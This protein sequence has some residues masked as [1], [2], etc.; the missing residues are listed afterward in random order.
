MVSVANGLTESA[1]Y[2]M[3][4]LEIADGSDNA[5][6]LNSLLWYTST[7]PEYHVVRKH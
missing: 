3:E 7:Q 1:T 2:E 4:V 5:T 6:Q